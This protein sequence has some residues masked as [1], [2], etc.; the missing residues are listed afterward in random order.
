MEIAAKKC[1]R[2]QAAVIWLCARFHK[3][4]DLWFLLEAWH[5]NVKAPD[6]Q[7]ALKL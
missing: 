7:T 5:L 4:K 1:T 3:C 2:T 6:L